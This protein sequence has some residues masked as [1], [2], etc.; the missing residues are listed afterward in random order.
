[1]NIKFSWDPIGETEDERSSDT[2]DEVLNRIF[3]EIE[4]AA[5]YEFEGYERIQGLERK[6]LSIENENHEEITKVVVLMYR[7]NGSY[8]IEIMSI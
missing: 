5:Y 3:D 7:N 4:G 2:F 1:M 6:I 8:E